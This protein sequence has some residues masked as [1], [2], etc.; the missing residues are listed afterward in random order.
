MC[1]CVYIYEVLGKVG[2]RKNIWRNSGQKFPKFD[3]NYKCTDTRISMHLK[4][5]KY[6]KKCTKAL[7]NQID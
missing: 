2:S 7:P 5:K 6:E 1:S 3:E 4:C